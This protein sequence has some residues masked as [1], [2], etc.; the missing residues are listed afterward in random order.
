MSYLFITFGSLLISYDLLDKYHPI[1]TIKELVVE[2]S[3]ILIV[4]ETLKDII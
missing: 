3:V 1:L 2:V 4:E